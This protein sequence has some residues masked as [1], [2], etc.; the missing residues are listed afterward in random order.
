MMKGRAMMDD[1]RLPS[2][3]AAV[4]S[5]FTPGSHPYLKNDGEYAKAFPE[6]KGDGMELQ[7]QLL[8]QEQVPPMAAPLTAPHEQ[9]EG[10]GGGSS[11]STAANDAGLLFLDLDDKFFQSW[12]EEGDG[13][14]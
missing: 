5:G 4:D 14:W 6:A 12:D 13:G 11:S 8:V 3:Y 9:Q 7:Q 10:A 1:G 2:P